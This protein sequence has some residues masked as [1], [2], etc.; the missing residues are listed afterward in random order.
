MASRDGETDLFETQESTES[1][2]T[3]NDSVIRFAA[4]RRDLLV[5]TEIQ[6]EHKHN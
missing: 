2:T 5:K 6:Q 1:I 3:Q 4:C